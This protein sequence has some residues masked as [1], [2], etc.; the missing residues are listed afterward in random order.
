M[1]T[2]G[3]AHLGSCQVNTVVEHPR[4]ATGSQQEFHRTRGGKTKG[5]NCWELFGAEAQS[6]VYGVMYIKK[7]LNC[8][9][10][11]KMFAYS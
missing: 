7:R 3:S 1:N 10:F 5:C 9:V 8:F 6:G 2:L 4:H 11:L